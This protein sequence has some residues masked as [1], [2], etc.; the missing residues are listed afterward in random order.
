MRNPTKLVLS[1]IQK[2]EYEYYRFGGIFSDS[3]QSKL[4]KLNNRLQR[5]KSADNKTLNLWNA[6][7]NSMR[8]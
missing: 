8:G 1:L 4:Y 6:N 7:I 2:L 3:Q 5:C